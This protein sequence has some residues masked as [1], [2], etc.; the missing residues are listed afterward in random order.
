MLND[1]NKHF[2]LADVSSTSNSTRE[3]HEEVE[4]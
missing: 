1:S 2:E 3:D 4:S